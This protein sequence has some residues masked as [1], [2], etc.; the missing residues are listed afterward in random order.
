MGKLTPTD[1]AF[2][3]TFLVV[4]VPLYFFTPMGRMGD[5]VS[6]IPA[7]VAVVIAVLV[8]VYVEGRAKH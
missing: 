5:P 4:W 1:R 6:M 7:F 2:G 8:W 3:W